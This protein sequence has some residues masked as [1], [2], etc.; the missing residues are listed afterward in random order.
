MY[1]NG[2]TERLSSG[3]GGTKELLCI[4]MDIQRLSSGKGGTKELLCITT[5]KR[6]G[7]CSVA[8]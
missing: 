7:L 4:T 6:E 3:K 1:Y 8:T 2:Y 5:G